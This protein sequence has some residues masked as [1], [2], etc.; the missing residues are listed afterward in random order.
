[1]TRARPILGPL[2]SE[3]IEIAK[4]A[5]QKCGQNN[6]LYFSIDAMLER[7]RRERGRGTDFFA[8]KTGTGGII[9]AEFLV[10]AMQM[11]ENV[12]E[13][14]WTCAVDSLREREQLTQAETDQL[15]QAYQFLRRCESVLRRYENSSV[16]TLPVDLTDQFK[17][18][19]RLGFGNAEA[20][21]QEYE[22][23]RSSIHQ[24]Y[25]R[26]IKELAAT[27]G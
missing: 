8:L 10:Q 2:Q 3:F 14:N 4:R 5:W 25:N 18:C 24:I 6:D 26:R 22:V 7:I 12:W 17:F 11:R 27:A 19:R 9:E 15:K 21:P 13:P 23:A 1:M 16:S 20:F